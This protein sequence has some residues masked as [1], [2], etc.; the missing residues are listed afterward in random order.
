MPTFKAQGQVYHLAEKFGSLLPNRS[1]KYKFLHIYFI[2]DT[3]TQVTT[4]CNIDS[5]K[6]LDSSLIRSLQD[7]LHSYNIYIQSFKSA[8]ESVP[9][10]VLDYNIVIH[11]SR[12]PTGEH[13]GRYNAPSTSEVAVVI[14]GQQFNERDIVFCSQDDNLKNYPKFT[15]LMIAYNIL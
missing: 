2:A 7:M 9:P 8:I 3:E 14:S 4:R 11:A 6:L 10:N 13:R 5:R 15:D 12:V 1:D